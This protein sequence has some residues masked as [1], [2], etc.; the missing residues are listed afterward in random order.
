MPTTVHKI[1]MHGPEIISSSLLLIGLMFEEA[2]ESYNKSIEK[3]RKDFS[4]KNSIKQTME[5]VFLRLLI[6]SKNVKCTLF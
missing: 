4:R 3:F 5:D 2:H 1:L 6:M